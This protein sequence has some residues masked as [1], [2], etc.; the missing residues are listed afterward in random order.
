MTNVAPIMVTRQ[1]G[2]EPMDMDCPNCNQHIKTVISHKVGA[3]TWVLCIF[4]GILVFC[5]DCSKEIGLVIESNRFT[6]RNLGKPKN[7]CPPLLM[8]K[9]RDLKIRTWNIDAHRAILI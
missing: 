3:L 2:P 9:A 5:C 7:L 8:Y 1:F 4:V 6:N